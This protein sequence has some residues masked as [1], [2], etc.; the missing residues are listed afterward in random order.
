[1]NFLLY[2]TNQS[3]LDDLAFWL[4]YSKDQSKDDPEEQK[5]VEK[6]GKFID[7]RKLFFFLLLLLKRKKI[8]FVLLIIVCDD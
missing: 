2:K 6:L 8:I 1:M 5:A 7:V 3:F 4:Q